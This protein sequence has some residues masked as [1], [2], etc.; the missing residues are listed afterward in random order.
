MK[1]PTQLFINCSLSK[2]C[3]AY[4]FKIKIIYTQFQKNQ[5]SSITTSS[6]HNIPSIK[7]GNSILKNYSNNFEC[8]NVCFSRRSDDKLVF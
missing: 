6:T 4:Q 1:K 3:N 8:H 5:F 7:E 2:R